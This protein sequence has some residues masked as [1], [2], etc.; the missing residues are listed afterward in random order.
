[1]K[2]G[3]SNAQQK[4]VP[5]PERNA[6]R[7]HARCPLSREN[8]GISHSSLC[9]LPTRE[10]RRGIGRRP[11]G[12]FGTQAVGRHV[13]DDP[14]R[15]RLTAPIDRIAYSL[16]GREPSIAH[17]HPYSACAPIPGGHIAGLD[18]YGLIEAPGVSAL[19][20]RRSSPCPVLVSAR[21]PCVVCSG[22]ASHG[23]FLWPARKNDP[24]RRR[25]RSPCW[26]ESRPGRS[27]FHG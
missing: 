26:I 14:V 16:R 5:V 6:R 9:R 3:C 15:R 2:C 13:G 25:L 7:W 22:R 27:H 4:K 24:Q 11:R 20:H 1:M 12:A 8:I 18:E 10:K 23:D 21:C 19:E 17:L